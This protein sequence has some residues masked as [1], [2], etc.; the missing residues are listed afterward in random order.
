MLRNY[1]GHLRSAKV[2]SFPTKG[3]EI[4]LRGSPMMIKAFTKMPGY[5][6]HSTR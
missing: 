6:T 5:L 3:R 1:C 2:P 4:L